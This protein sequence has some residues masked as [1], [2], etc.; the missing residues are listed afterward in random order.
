MDPIFES[1]RFDEISR[2]ICKQ[3][4]EKDPDKRLGANGCDEIMSHPWFKDIKWE[5]IISD[6]K[7]PPF[8]PPRDVNAASQAEIGTF[9]ED[10]KFQETTYDEKDD[11]IYHTWDW[12]NSS[13][14]SAEVIEVLIY[15]R[16]TG[17]RLVPIEPNSSCCCT[18]I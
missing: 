1:K 10:K 4:I 6:K 18:L 13:A 15:E 12:T 7:N 17:K 8:V 11:L 5:E 14:Y 16:K 2:D 3:L 9:P